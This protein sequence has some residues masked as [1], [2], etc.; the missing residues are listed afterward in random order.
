MQGKRDAQRHLGIFVFL[1]VISAAVFWPIRT[2]DFINYDDQLYLTQNRVVQ[3]GLTADGV[4]WAFGRLVGNGTYWHPLTWISHM[5]DC[6]MFKMNAGRHHLVS[7]VFHVANVLLLFALLNR[8]SGKAWRSAVVAALFA[9]HPLQVDSVAWL[10][11]RK[12]LLST[13]FGLVTMHFYSVYTRKNSKAA[14]GLALF[15]FALTLMSKPFVTLPCL[16]LLLDF[17]PL[18]RFSR[19]ELNGEKSKQPSDA[20]VVPVSRLILEKLPFFALSFAS[21]I[22]TILAHKQ[23][24]LITESHQMSLGARLANASVAY[25][26]YVRK[27]FWPDD[28]AVYYPLPPAWPKL[29]L[30]GAAI[31]VIGVCL[32]AFWSMRR[33]PYIFTGWFWFFGTLV[34]FIGL[35][36]VN[37]Q[38]MADRFAYIP[39]I[40]LFI[41]LTWSIAEALGKVS[42]ST[43][44]GISTV[45]IVAA[46]WATSIQV[47][48]WKNSETLFRH[49]IKVSES[50]IA[51]INLA[52]AIEEAGTMEKLVEARQHYERAIALVPNNS[53]AESNLGVVLAKMGQLNEAMPHFLKAVDI[54]PDNADAHSNLGLAYTYL[55]QP[56]DAI[57]SLKEAIRLK[58]EHGQAGHNLANA[59]AQQGL[60]EEALPHYEKAIEV[61]PNDADV[62]NNLGFALFKLQRM[63]EARK[64]FEA[65]LSVRPS[66]AQAHYNLAMI[67]KQEGNLLEAKRHYAAALEGNPNYAEAHFELGSILR[68]EGAGS[69]ARFHL[70]Q[71]LRLRPDWKS[72]L[73]PMLEGSAGVN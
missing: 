46:V 57:K 53:M 41:A 60:L 30:I 3:G 55:K 36:Q 23:L 16:L 58:P 17:W 20:G 51:H 67:S 4:K 6:S 33:R 52:A 8:I 39:L 68:Q 73:A 32:F 42:L 27:V 70:E 25:W 37:D 2:H 50:N 65:A 71:A 47:G 29:L 62:R 56:E 24:A 11:E 44:A 38:A 28:L 63:A 22:I 5:A 26:R 49:A 35:L 9:V 14:Y 43:K 72:Q 64:Y 7:L 54:N 31:F 40:G 45:A 13:F 34:P 66:H 15:S 69:E 48:H 19:V 12:N 10:A 1:A 21:G 18:R 59:L 61:L